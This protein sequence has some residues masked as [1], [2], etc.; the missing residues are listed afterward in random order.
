[1]KIRTTKKAVT[2][3]HGH[4]IPLSYCSAQYLLRYS[5]PIAYTAGTNGWNADVYDAGTDAIVTGYRP[6][7][8]VRVN[9]DTVNRYEQLA[10]QIVESNTDYN[11]RRGLV[12]DLLRDLVGQIKIEAGILAVD[13]N[14]NTYEPDRA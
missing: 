1:M 14:G 9:Y 10:Q 2:E 13:E 5:Q 7:G 3:A 4:V 11:V 6:F 8:D 12:L